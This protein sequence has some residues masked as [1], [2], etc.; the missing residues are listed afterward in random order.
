MTQ[1][2]IRGFD[3]DL[4]SALKRLAQ[5]EG[6]SLNRAALK[7][8]RRGAGLGPEAPP[9]RR[10]GERLDRFLGTWSDAEE[11]EFLEAV[12]ELEGIDQDLWR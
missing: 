9:A 4:E 8:L 6:I 7:L 1:L 2:T 5:V 10:I 11:R 3:P 12:E